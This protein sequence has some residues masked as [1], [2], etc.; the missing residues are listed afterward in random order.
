MIYE[1]GAIGGMQILTGE[2]LRTW[3]KSC[4]GATLSTTNPTWTNPGANW[5]LRCGRAATNRLIHG[6]ASHHLGDMREEETVEI[7]ATENYI[8]KR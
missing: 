7:L 5:G 2:N 3:R 1:Y 6:K 8:W 4:P